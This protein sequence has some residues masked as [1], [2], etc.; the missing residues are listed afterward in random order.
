MTSM[1]SKYPVRPRLNQGGSPTATVS[2]NLNEKGFQI[3]TQKRK[4]LGNLTESS[5]NAVAS[6]TRSGRGGKL[7]TA[8][9]LVEKELGQQT[10]QFLS[11]S[12]DFT[13]VKITREQYIESAKEPVS[14]LAETNMDVTPS[15]SL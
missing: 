15:P 1:A 12:T 13:E 3:V 2:S 10:I 5:I 8:T 4:A 9:K 14:N 7:L 6:C 11:P